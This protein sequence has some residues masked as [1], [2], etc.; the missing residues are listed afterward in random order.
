M[1][2]RFSIGLLLTVIAVCG[3]GFAALRSPSQLW[4]STLF[5]VAL[6]SLPLALLTAI[7]SRER[8]RAF[9]VG[10]FMVGGSYFAASQ[11][12]GFRDQFGPR[13]VTTKLLDL[14]YD[15][16]APP[17]VGMA[18][19]LLSDVRSDVNDQLSQSV[20]EALTGSGGTMRLE[21]QWSALTKPDHVTGVDLQVSLFTL[22]SPEAFR[23]I[24]HSLLTLIFAL[25]GGLYACRLHA[26]LTP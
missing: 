8:R 12:P 14:L 16:V 26:R 1:R 2:P 20:K 23:R 9:W 4:A 7:Y 11:G 10:F 6:G 13:M 15:R 3:I 17:Q 22:A 21:S 18:A 19:I 5:A 25:L 24:G